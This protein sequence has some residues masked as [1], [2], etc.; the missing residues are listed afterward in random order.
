[1]G[2][3]KSSVGRRVAE[4]LGR[5]FLDTDHVVEERSGRS[6]PD[7]FAAGEEAAFRALEADAVRDL[8]ERPPMVLALGGGALEDPA[9]R[10]LLLERALVVHLVVSWPQLR[11][12]L[13]GLAEGRPL[14]RGRSEEEI[15]ALYERRRATYRAAHLQIEAPRGKL[16]GGGRPG[17]RPHRRR[18]RVAARAAR[19]GRSGE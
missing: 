19:G 3:G 5:P 8:V 16:A 12:A 2:A 4:R 1:M 11:A 14:L 9:T 15:R 18:R 17:A 10:A 7:F 13:P 6:I